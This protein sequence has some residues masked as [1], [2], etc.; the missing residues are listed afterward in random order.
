VQRTIVRRAR[1]VGADPYLASLTFEDP[2]ELVNRFADLL[3][4]YWETAFAREW[5]R[6]EPLLADTVTTS[7]ADLPP[8]AST[9]S[10]AECRRGFASTPS[11]RSS[12]L[13]S[14]TTTG[15]K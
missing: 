9:R 13:I 8:T 2:R 12:G 5:H 4:M 6:L 1:A 7:G 15:W 3:E 14:R 11:A 10:F